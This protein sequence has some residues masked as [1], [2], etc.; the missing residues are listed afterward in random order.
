MLL[1]Y[2]RTLRSRR[3]QRGLA[4][5]GLFVIAFTLCAQTLV[6]QDTTAP[7][8]DATQNAT[9]Q[10]L[11]D[12]FGSYAAERLNSDR[13]AF[14][15]RAA[16]WFASRHDVSLERTVIAAVTRQYLATTAV[17]LSPPAFADGVFLY[18]AARVANGVLEGRNFDTRR[19]FGGFVPYTIRSQ[20]LS[21]RRTDSRPLVWNFEE[22]G[23]STAEAQRAALALHTLERSL[24]WASMQQA[25]ATFFEQFRSNRAGRPEL[26]AILTEQRGVD[27]SKPFADLFNV[28]A[29]FDYGIEG[30]SSEQSSSNAA[31]F[32]STV[33]LRRFGDATLASRSVPMVVSFEDGSEITEWWD[34][35]EQQRD[36]EYDSRS[37]AVQ[38]VVDPDVLLVV[39]S[40]R[41]NNGRTLQPVL[42]RAAVRAIATWLV[43]LQDV[44]LT[45]SSLV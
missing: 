15:A 37:R 17:E 13:V 28:A 26:A 27:V 14:D 12:W 25:L 4:F 1:Y 21:R 31:A 11:A 24:G 38:A 6:A 34:G 18:A 40:N 20:S 8:V 29:N 36:F 22:F 30:L 45:Y 43:W 32:R 41:S 3:Q 7:R 19:V 10:Y 5:C 35:R 33:R 9:L 23:T 39:D 44:M 2:S 16:D 42:P